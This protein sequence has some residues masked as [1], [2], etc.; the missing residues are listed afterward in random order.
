MIGHVFI[1]KAQP[2]APVQEVGEYK[3]P[4]PDPIIYTLH[5]TDNKERAESWR[6]VLAAGECPA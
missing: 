6:Q 4:G 2:G 3:P 5:I 1:F